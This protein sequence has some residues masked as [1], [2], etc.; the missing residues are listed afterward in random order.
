MDIIRAALYIRVSTDEQVREGY[1]LEAQKAHLLEY[2]KKNGYS[3]VGLYADEGISA[4]KS[5]K[6]RKEFMRLISDVEAGKVD[7]ILFIK[8]DRW[9]RSVADYHK[10]Q[11]ILEANNVGW[12]ATTEQYDTTTA[13]GRLYVNIRLAVAQDEADRTS[14]RIKFVFDR[15]VAESQII[16]GRV[17]LGYKK[18]GNK[19]VVDE[20]GA[21]VVRRI[22]DM[23]INLRSRRAIVFQCPQEFGRKFSYRMLETMLKNEKYIGKYRD[24]PNYCPAIIEK[25]VFNEAQAIRKAGA[26]RSQSSNDD[27][28][29]IF[30]GLL[31]CPV[32]GKRL[33]GCGVSSYKEIKSFYRY[34]RCNFASNSSDCSNK[35][36]V[37]E[38]KI[39]KYLLENISKEVAKYKVEY[40]LRIKKRQKPAIN[41]RTIENKL[42]KLR[43]LYINDLIAIAD[44]K[45]EYDALNDELKRADVVPPEEE[46]DF[47]RLEA[48]LASGFENMY[49]TLDNKAKRA[50]WHTIIEKIVKRDD[51]GFDIFFK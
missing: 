20:E 16:S 41:K 50:L 40:E 48:L 24:N 4:R 15:K 51:G 18:D 6:K 46:K 33:S 17:P 19:L 11:E 38:K 32:C 29:Y 21:E 45:K 43:E 7:L 30:S 14:E 22:F 36:R 35:R 10:V 12:R 26:L 5:Y 39:E 13:G 37:S 1:S 34:Y 9:F 28:F 42:A 8:L 2:A 47:G 25:S 3:V 27:Y 31:V 44:Y 23:Y 49:H